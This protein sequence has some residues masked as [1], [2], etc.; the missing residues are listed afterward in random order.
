[1]FGCCRCDQ[2][3]GGLDGVNGINEIDFF[4][5]RKGINE[6]DGSLFNVTI[7]IDQ[8][9]QHATKIA[10]LSVITTTTKHPTAT[11]PSIHNDLPIYNFFSTLYPTFVNVI[12][13][14]HRALIQ[15]VTFD[16]FNDFF[17]FRRKSSSLGPFGGLTS[18]H[19][20]I[21]L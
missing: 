5:L 2:E 11:K 8:S 13:I 15:F 1:M 12:G 17:A 20:I 18:W 7:I 14:N 9:T 10:P 4:F 21:K 6:I 16:Y 3:R 19:D